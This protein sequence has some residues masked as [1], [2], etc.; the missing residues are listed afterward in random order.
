MALRLLP[1]L[2]AAWLACPWT[3]TGDASSAGGPRPAHGPVQDPHQRPSITDPARWVVREDL[4]AKLPKAITVREL[5]DDALPL[6]GWLVTARPDDSW[7]PEASQPE[8]GLRTTS[9][10]AAALG[11]IVAINAGFFAPSGSVSTVVDEGEVACCGPSSVSREGSPYPVTRAAIGFDREGRA[12]CAWTWCFDRVVYALEAPVANAPG[13]PAKAPT[14]DQG[15][16]WEG[17]EELLGAGPMLVAHGALHNTEVAECFQS[18]GGT[19]RHPRTAAGWAEDGTLLLLVLDGRSKTSRGA[20]LDETAAILLAH[21][22]HEALNLDGG[23]STTLWVAGQ[24][25]NQPSDKA[26]ERPVASI[27][28]LVP[29]PEPRD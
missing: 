12:D 16:P 22:A 1:W 28:A 24:V 14:R 7:R 6:H 26:G 11:A 18:L 25:L 15:R 2:A 17:V 13:K 4:Q 3:A 9:A 19:S 29:E 23:G 10:Q 20:T 8:T 5:R 21:G 27:L